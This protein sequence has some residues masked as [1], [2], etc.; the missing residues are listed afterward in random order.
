[1]H[2][3][4]SYGMDD[5]TRY[6]FFYKIKLTCCSSLTQLIFYLKKVTLS[7][8]FFVAKKIYCICLDLNTS[9]VLSDEASGHMAYT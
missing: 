2:V 5:V 1:M 9:C 8:D 7:A 4:M 6:F 3:S